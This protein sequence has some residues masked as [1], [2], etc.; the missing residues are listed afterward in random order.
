MV[1]SKKKKVTR[2]PNSHADTR[3]PK[4]NLVPKY[5]AQGIFFNWNNCHGY[6]WIM[7][8]RKQHSRMCYSESRKKEI[9]GRWRMRQ[10][11]SEIS[12]RLKMGF[13]GNKRS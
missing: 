11:E 9:Q 1:V 5:K 10:E 13:S 8:A 4:C 2:K 7:Q 3:N 12:K 6:E